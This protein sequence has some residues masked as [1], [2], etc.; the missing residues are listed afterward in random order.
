MTIKRLFDM[1]AASIGLVVLSPVMAFIAI[2]VARRMGPPVMFTQERIGLNGRAFALRKFR[3][4]IDARD[5]DGKL[6]PDADRL[7]PFGRWLRRTSLDELPE[8][9]NVLRGEMSVVGPR[10]LLPQ[11]LRRYNARQARRHDVRPGL[12]GLAQV[13]GRNRLSWEERLELDVQYVERGSLRLD[14]WIV[15]KTLAKVLSGEG[16]SQPGHET[17][18]EFMGTPEAK[19]DVR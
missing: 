12:T 9:V 14:A 4:M 13:S 10:P 3:T 18:E 17:S 2:A 7:T 8:L 16:V 15:M 1:T 5:A 6:L 11:Y 19:S